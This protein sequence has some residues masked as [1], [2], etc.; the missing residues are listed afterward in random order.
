MYTK[1]C[2]PEY[3]CLIRNWYVP[4]T[5]FWIRFLS[6]SH[7]DTLQLN[8]ISAVSGRLFRPSGCFFFYPRFIVSAFC[9]PHLVIRILH[10]H[11]FI[12]DP[13]F[14]SGE[15]YVWCYKKHF[16]EPCKQST[17]Y[18]LQHLQSI[19]ALHSNTEIS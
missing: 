15:P 7:A 1:N 12:S 10:P 17:P 19:P 8:A 11:F 9:F 2:V 18:R 14:Y 16:C 6:D 13:L 3:L 5:D 4:G